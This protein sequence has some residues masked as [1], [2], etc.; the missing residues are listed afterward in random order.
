[1]NL[2]KLLQIAEKAPGFFVLFLEIDRN[3]KI[4]SKNYFLRKY[5]TPK[6][7]IDL[8]AA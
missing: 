8:C 3:T 2:Q 7:K 1:M 5:F 4:C 6:I